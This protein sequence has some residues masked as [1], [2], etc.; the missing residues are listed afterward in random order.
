MDNCESFTIEQKKFHVE[1]F[2][3]LPKTS[4]GKPVL[5][6]RKYSEKIGIDQSTF[7]KWMKKYNNGDYNNIPNSM[8]RKRTRE[9]EYA[10]VE[11][12]LVEY[13]NQRIISQDKLGLSHRYLQ[14]KALEFCKIVYPAD[15]EEIREFR[16]SN[17]W[18]SNVLKRN[19]FDGLTLH[20]EAIETISTS[21]PDETLVEE[22][23][24]EIAIV[25]P[26]ALSAE[27]RKKN[28]LQK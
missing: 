13:I 28:I 10:E 15:S 1:T 21:K 17:G 23:D 7:T 12:K 5:S 18:L 3:K 19:N 6:Q 25:A 16:A 26:V 2:L 20:D 4:S 11:K 27:D 8:T 14:N 9:S 24:N 22:K